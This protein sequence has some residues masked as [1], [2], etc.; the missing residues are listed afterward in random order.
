MTGMICPQMNK[1]NSLKHTANQKHEK[2]NSNI[3]VIPL[4]LFIHHLAQN[5]VAPFMCNILGKINIKLCKLNIY[6]ACFA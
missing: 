2:N 4:E 1:K 6:Y 5:L 3:V